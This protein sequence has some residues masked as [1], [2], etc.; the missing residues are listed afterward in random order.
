LDEVEPSV[1]KLAPVGLAPKDA[2]EPIENAM[3]RADS[4]RAA[5]WAE[6]GHLLTLAGS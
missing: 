4:V 6:R 1:T 3:R 2:Q 5:I